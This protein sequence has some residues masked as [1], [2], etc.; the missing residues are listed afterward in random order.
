MRRYILKNHG[1]SST[2]ENGVLSPTLYLFSTWRTYFH[3]NFWF[4]QPR[5]YLTA[6][7][8]QLRFL[9]FCLPRKFIKHNEINDYT[10]AQ[11]RYKTDW[12]PASIK[13]SVFASYINFILN[14]SSFFR[15]TSRLTD[16]PSIPRSNNL[17]IFFLICHEFFHAL[18]FA[19][20][21]CVKSIYYMIFVNFRLHARL[22]FLI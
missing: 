13:S 14:T 17:Q 22:A 18:R 1:N 16:L 4:R 12:W 20:H 9:F 11:D 10:F 3:R 19:S 15:D 5:N 7:L 8:L 21:F 2:I 6:T